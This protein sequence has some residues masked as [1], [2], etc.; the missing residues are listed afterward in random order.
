MYTQNYR[1]KKDDAKKDLNTV[2]QHL[3]FKNV[4][5]AVIN[6]FPERKEKET[7]T[8]ECYKPRIKPFQEFLDVVMD[9]E[10]SMAT[11][12]ILDQQEL[13]AEE[14]EESVEPLAASEQQQGELQP[15]ELDLQNLFNPNDSISNFSKSK[16]SSVTSTHRKALAEQAALLAR[17]RHRE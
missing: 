14:N 13:P 12:S 9:W 15:P 7:D 4:H 2:Q 17:R 5:K 3:V 11:Q 16:S 1:T 6:V 10:E 8:A